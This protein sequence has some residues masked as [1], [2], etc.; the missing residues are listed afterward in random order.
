MHILL[1]CSIYNHNVTVNKDDKSISTTCMVCKK[2][3]H[4]NQNCIECDNCR[5]K[6]HYK[7]TDLNPKKIVALCMTK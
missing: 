5:N 1:L 6:F 7:C 3:C 4:K 2:R